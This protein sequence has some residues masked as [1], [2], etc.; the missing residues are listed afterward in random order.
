MYCRPELGRWALA[1]GV[2][3][4]ALWGAGGAVAQAPSAVTVTDDRGQRLTLPRPPQRIVSLLPSLTESV[5]ALQACGRLVGVDRYSNWPTSVQALPR[6]GGLEDTQVERLV[7]LKPDLV[8]AAVSARVIDRLQALGIPVLALEPQHW[9]GTQRTLI[10]LAQVLGDAP[11]GPA[12][13]ARIEARVVAAAARVPASL[14]GRAVYFEVA[15][16][17]YAAGEASFIGELLGRL[18]LANIVPAAMGPFP[19][20]NPEFVIRAQPALVMASAEAV[21][22][23]PGRPGWAALQAPQ[24]GRVC[25]FGAAAMDTLVRPGPRL[26]EGAEAIADCLATMRP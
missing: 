7:A 18:A 8:L 12:L 14:R 9:S 3:L 19:K 20:L 24:R 17:P 21:A 4:A 1:L 2:A 26:A 16:S 23:M 15:S 13:V 25:G 22:E 11:A 5:C 6:L 10:T